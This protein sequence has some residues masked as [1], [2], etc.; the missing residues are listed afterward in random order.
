M[1]NNGNYEHQGTPE[2][3][4]MANKLTLPSDPDRQNEMINLGTTSTVQTDPK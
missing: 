2:M 3:E 4:Q 1:Q